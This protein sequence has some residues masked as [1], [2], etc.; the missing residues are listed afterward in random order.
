V[1]VSPSILIGDEHF[2]LAKVRLLVKLISGNRIEIVSPKIE[3]Q[4]PDVNY[5]KVDKSV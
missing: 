2:S 3:N 1:L 4:N 5:I